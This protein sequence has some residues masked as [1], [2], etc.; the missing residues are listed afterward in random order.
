MS[1]ELDTERAV[2]RQMREAT[3]HLDVD[4]P[5]FQHVI[6]RSRSLRRRRMAAIA[7][8]VIVAVALAAWGVAELAG[9]STG[10]RTVP[11][12]TGGNH[13]AEPTVAGIERISVGSEIG[14]LAVAEG[15]VWAL[16]YSD[17]DRDR[18]IQLDPATGKAESA[19]IVLHSPLVSSFAVGD[20][21]VWAVEPT[22]T[23]P[24]WDHEPGTLLRLDPSTGATI[25]S[26]EVGRHPQ[27]VL[28]GGGYVWVANA[29]D[30]T[31]TKVDPATNRAVVAIR[32]G[33]GPEELA[34]G[35]GTL[36]VES[37]FGTVNLQRIDP[38]T[39]AIVATIPQVIRPVMGN[40]VVWVGGP[41]RPNG[42]VLQIDPSSNRFVGKPF[43]LDIGPSRVVAGEGSV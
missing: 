36:W 1:P 19:P 20:G 23:G 15:R 3:D 28:V 10:D 6:R 25:A 5:P 42:A 26:I 33:R 27:D 32:V 39:N 9:L 12:A 2:R 16:T 40:G 30:G 43:P 37:D 11:D 34:Y 41:G 8:S 7:C 14:E 18:I 17:D 22:L 24:S 38:V 13:S 21:S 31:V 35:I 4:T 29:A